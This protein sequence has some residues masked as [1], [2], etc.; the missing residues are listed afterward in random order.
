MLGL[1]FWGPAGNYLDKILI[2][3][4]NPHPIWKL[5]PACAHKHNSEC[6]HCQL[7]EKHGPTNFNFTITN[8]VCCRPTHTEETT[9]IVRLH[10]RNRQPTEA[11]INL[12]KSHITELFQNPFPITHVVCLGEV[13]NT[14]YNTLNRPEPALHLLHPAYIARQD[15]TQLTIIKQAE[16][17][18]R[19]IISKH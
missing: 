12:C 17:L 19:W 7:R 11:E 15:Y 6:E 14:T 2:E 3:C 16:S 5:I 10:G 1:A 8:T 4:S 9:P 18:R 13:A